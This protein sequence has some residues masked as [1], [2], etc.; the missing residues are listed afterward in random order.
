MLLFVYTTTRTR[1]VIFTGRYFK[2]SWNTTALSQSNCRNFSYSSIKEKIHC[3]SVW[4]CFLSSSAKLDSVKINQTPFFL[5]YFELYYLNAGWRLYATL[6]PCLSD[7]SASGAWGQASPVLLLLHP[8]VI[9]G[10]QKDNSSSLE[11]FIAGQQA[12][13]NFLSSSVWW[14]NQLS[15]SQG[16][17]LEAV[18]Y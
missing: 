1:F 6:Q 7:I 3:N 17:A 8:H 13:L 2:F 11:F 9:R 4:L 5:P 18:V 16:H 10:N 14:D 15:L 12:W